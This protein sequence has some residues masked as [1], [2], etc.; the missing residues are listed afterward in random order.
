MAVALCSGCATGPNPQTNTLN[1]LNFDRVGWIAAARV[2]GKG[3]GSGSVLGY[4]RISDWYIMGQ[5]GT[6]QVASVQL[7]SIRYVDQADWSQMGQS[8]AEFV[9]I[10]RDMIASEI[11]ANAQAGT[12]PRQPLG[13]S[14]IDF[15]PEIV[16]HIETNEGTRYVF[17]NIGQ[18][19]MC[20]CDQF[21]TGWTEKYDRATA[22]V[23]A[24][25]LQGPLLLSP[26]S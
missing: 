5:N 10:V 7:Q 24:R 21:G 13:L 23:I 22:R 19:E 16:V 1:N 25:D 9:A 20:I 3:G 18:R 8:G 6:T 17:V 2:L 26:G 14:A 15:Q 12:V 4:E 11:A